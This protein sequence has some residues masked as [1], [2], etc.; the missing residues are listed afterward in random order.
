MSVPFFDAS[1]LVKIS[2]R[3]FSICVTEHLLYCMHF[4]PVS[5]VPT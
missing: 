2:I 3:L 5:V 1:V 4:C